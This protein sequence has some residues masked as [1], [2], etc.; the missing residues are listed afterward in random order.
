MRE[1]PL[2][3]SFVVRAP[4]R[5]HLGFLDLHGGVGRRFGGLGMALAAPMTEIK[6]QP[7]SVFDVNGAADERIRTL[8]RQLFE[9]CGR[10]PYGGFTVRHLLPQHQGLGSG[11]QTALTVG[12]AVARLCGVTGDSRNIAQQTGRGQRSGIGIGAF[13]YGGFLVD[14]GKKDAAPPPIIVRMEIPQDW[15]VVLICCN[16]GSGIHGVAEKK[17][18]DNLPDFSEDSAEFLCRILVLGILPA[19]AQGDFATFA[20]MLTRVQDRIGDYF[21]VVQ[22]SRYAHPKVRAVLEHLRRH[23]VQCVGQSSWGP[24]G[25][26]IT[27]DAHSARQ[28]VDSIAAQFGRDFGIHVNVTQADNQGGSIANDN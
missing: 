2:P 1:M 22:G 7:Q 5:L 12:H 23:R 17:G 21:A 25:F 3:E 8:A 19:L 18:F 13:D 26:V 10:E 28:V 27:H 24:T 16:E 11:T 14:G 6:V 4:A 20:E 9:D 15:R